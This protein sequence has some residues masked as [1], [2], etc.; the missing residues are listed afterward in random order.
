MKA[1]EFNS[2]VESEGVIHIPKQ[3]LLKISSPVKIILFTNEETLPDKSKHFSAMKL[4]TKGFK[5]SRE[6]A[7]E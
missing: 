7:N 3:Y 6:L 5:F 1:Y 4:R 2:I